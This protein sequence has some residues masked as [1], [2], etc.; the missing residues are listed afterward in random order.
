MHPGALRA[1]EYDRIVSAAAKLARTPL[2]ARRLAALRPHT[3]ARHVAA[4]LQLTAE[5]ARLLAEGGDPAL[6]AP[7]DVDAVV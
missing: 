7:P 2:G 4:A 5:A 3:D 6:D 1:L